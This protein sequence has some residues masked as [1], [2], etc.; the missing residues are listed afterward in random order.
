MFHSSPGMANGSS[1]R[2]K[3]CQPESWNTRAASLSSGGTVRIDWYR[4]KAMFQACEVK[5]AKIAAHSTPSRLP[6]NKA[7]KRGNGDRL[8]AQDRDRLQDVEQRHQHLFGGPVFCGD[9]TRTRKLKSSDTAQRHE[10]AQ[11]GAQQVVGQIGRLER[12]RQW[13]GRR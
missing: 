11:D 12:D 5:M 10:H 13:V 2:Q 6:G 8:K 7:M 9:G 3:R 1:S 4:L